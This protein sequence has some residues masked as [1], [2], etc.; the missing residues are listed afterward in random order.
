VNPLPIRPTIR[1][2][3]TLV[4]G[5]MFLLAG[6]MLLALN[7]ALVRNSLDRDG[8]TVQLRTPPE[9]AIEPA[10][11]EPLIVEGAPASVEDYERRL[12]DATLSTLLVQSGQTLLIMALASLALGWLIAGRVLKPVH[13]MTAT[14]RRLS[15]ENL[16]ERIALRGPD[17]ELK[18]LADTFDAMLARLEAAFASQR[19]FVANASH[20]LRTPLSVIRSQIDVALADPQAS[21]ADLRAMGET[22]RDATERCERLIDSLL[23]LA[24]SD[25]GLTAGDLVALH[26]VTADAAAQSQGEATAAGVSLDLDLSPVTVRGDRGLLERLV[27]NLIQNAVRHNHAGGRAG[28]ELFPSVAEAVLRV[29]NTGDDVPADQVEAL[30]EP[31]RRLGAQRTGAA[32]RGVG[33]GLSI[34]RSVASAHGGS[35]S[36]RPRS[37]GGLE[38]EVR[39]PLA[40]A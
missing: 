15:Q 3:L 34:V 24:R 17:D 31:F 28:V 39:L 19:R 40:P 2:R 8:V 4:Y 6:V 9:F 5:G 14:A 29:T 26:E 1:L 37:G 25:R 33:L 23:V 7:Y 22:V 12:R 32:R 38:V 16:N 21:V 10:T 30:F 13:E 20:E 11:P 35:V 36:A 27:T 18:E